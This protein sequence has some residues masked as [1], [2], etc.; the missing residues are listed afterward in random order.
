M[1]YINWLND[2]ENNAHIDWDNKCVMWDT[3]DSHDTEAMIKDLFISDSKYGIDVD[4]FY[5]AINEGVIN[6][7]DLCDVLCRFALD[8][9]CDK[10]LDLAAFA[11]FSFRDVIDD[12]CRKALKDM[13]DPYDEDVITH[14]ETLMELDAARPRG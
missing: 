9:K 1:M 8:T 4:I 7:A 13:E 3:V 2:I 12:L 11:K 10:A 5:D 14:A 6:L